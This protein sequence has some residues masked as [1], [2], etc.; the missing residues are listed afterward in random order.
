MNDDD[1]C[2][3]SRES[4]PK[5][6]KYMKYDETKLNQ[7]SGITQNNI[8]HSELDLFQHISVSF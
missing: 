6:E 2:W 3:Q 1:I 7:E 4:C 8:H 5:T